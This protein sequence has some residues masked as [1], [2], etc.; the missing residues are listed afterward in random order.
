VAQFKGDVNNNGRID[1]IDAVLI[2]PV[3]TGILGDEDTLRRSDINGDGTVSTDDI[4]VLLKHLNG[5]E[6]IDEVIY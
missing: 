1:L 3:A 4:F 2:L 5:E 6:L